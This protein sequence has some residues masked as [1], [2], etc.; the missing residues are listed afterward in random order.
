MVIFI[1]LVQY[2]KNLGG[3]SKKNLV[4]HQIIKDVGTRKR[5][6]DFPRFFNSL[7]WTRN[8]NY[9]IGIQNMQN[10]FTFLAPRNLNRKTF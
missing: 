4:E 3:K 2:A 6:H 1:E 5:L 8:I 10:L 7:P 9:N